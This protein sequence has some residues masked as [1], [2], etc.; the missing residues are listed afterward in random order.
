MTK[1]AKRT[2]RL[3]MDVTIRGEDRYISEV[4]INGK[5]IPEKA[6]LALAA[7]LQRHHLSGRSDLHVN[8]QYERE[9]WGYAG[10]KVRIYRPIAKGPARMTRLYAMRSLRDVIA[11]ARTMDA[12]ADLAEREGWIATYR[13]V[14]KDGREVWVSVPD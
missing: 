5:R 12:L 9:P 14:T 7:T 6:V 8:A 11:T 4:R 10:M 13:H 2:V 3:K 1:N